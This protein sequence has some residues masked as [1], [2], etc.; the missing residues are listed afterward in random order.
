MFFLWFIKSFVFIFLLVPYCRDLSHI[1]GSQGQASLHLRLS[2]SR[3]QLGS[4]SKVDYGRIPT[5]MYLYEQFEKIYIYICISCI[6]IYYKDI[7]MEV[8]LL[9]LLAMGGIVLG[10]FISLMFEDTRNS[11][12]KETAKNWRWNLYQPN[13][14]RSQLSEFRIHPGGYG[15][16]RGFFVI[17]VSESAEI[18]WWKFPSSH[19]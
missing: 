19:F 9:L 8:L 5:Y 1:P 14:Q 18:S 4:S 7:N 11:Q 15:G 3:W 16:R 2:R 13:F 6:Y 17:I 12:E 10:N